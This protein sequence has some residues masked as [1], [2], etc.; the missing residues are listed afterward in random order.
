MVCKLE[1]F[2]NDQV[3]R[4]PYCGYVAHKAHMLEWLHVKDYCPICHHH[5]DEE[6]LMGK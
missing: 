5:L 6:N 3:V 2:E 4:C 1:I